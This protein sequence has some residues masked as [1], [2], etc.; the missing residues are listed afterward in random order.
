MSRIYSHIN[1]AKAILNLYKGELPFSTFLKNFFAKE[2]KYGSRDRRTISSICYNY[3]RLGFAYRHS[4][5]E[6]KLLVSEFLCN[7]VASEFLQTEKP[8]WNERITAPL[9]E[10]LVLAGVEVE[11]VFPFND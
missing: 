3:F 1:T 9:G 2:K 8:E 5:I 11:K 6:E 7:S 4:V 10:K